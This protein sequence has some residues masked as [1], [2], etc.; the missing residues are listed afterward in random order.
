MPAQCG[1]RAIPGGSYRIQ[2]SETIT[3]ASWPVLG[4]AS[5]NAAGVFQFID[6]TNAARRFYRA[7]YP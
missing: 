4:S 7:V 1:A 2:F 6:A 3:N 5:A